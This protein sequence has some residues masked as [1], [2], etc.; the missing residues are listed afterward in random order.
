MHTPSSIFLCQTSLDKAKFLEFGIKN[1]KLATLIVSWSN[2]QVSVPR[3]LP[4][5]AFPHRNPRPFIQS[6]AT[7]NP[8]LKLGLVATAAGPTPG[9]T[10][11]LPGIA[12]R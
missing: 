1:A 6:R 9:I 12:Q 11:N 2:F 10:G 8:R 4:F 3:A 7:A 5:R